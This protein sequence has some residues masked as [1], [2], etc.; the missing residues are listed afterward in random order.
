M[1]KGILCILLSIVMLVPMLTSCTQ[2]A[3]LTGVEASVYTLYT[4][5]DEKTTPEAIR[6]VELA[7]NRILFYRLNVILKLEMVSEAEYDKLIEDKFAEM[8][9]YEETRNEQSLSTESESSESG[10]SKEVLTGDKILDLLEDGKEIPLKE[11]RLDI[12]LVRGYDKYYDLASNNMLSALD[13]KLSNEAKALK[14]SIHSTF[15]N[16]A[17]VN[18]KTYG[19]PVNKAIGEYTYM[20]FDSE[21]LEK[22]NVDPNTI[23][24][25]EDLEDYLAL[26]KEGEEG[27]VPLK[28][29]KE[30]ANLQFL[31]ENGFPA[32]VDKEGYVNSAY[33][34]STAGKALKKY[35][36]MIARYQASGYFGNTA[37]EDGAEDTNR[38]AV[39]IESGSIDEINKRLDADKDEYQFSLYSNPIA[40]NENTID[41]I[42][43]VSKYVVSNELTD[44]MKIVSALNTD[45]ELMNILTY[46]VENEHYKLDDNGQVERLNENYMIAPEHAGNS[47]ITYT[48]HGESPN[49]WDDAIRQ[50]QDAIASPSLGFTMVPDTYTYEED[51]EEI[52]VNEPDYVGV[53]N[54]IIVEKYYPLFMSGTAVE[55]DYDTLYET[56]KEEITNEFITELNTLYE[57][58]ILKP[59]F[60]A[61]L[62]DEITESEGPEL[63]ANATAYVMSVYRNDVIKTLTNKLKKE[64]AEAN[65][66]ASEDDILDYVDDTLTDEYIDEHF[67]DYYSDEVVEEMINSVYLDDLNVVIDAA[68]EEMT[69]SNEYI[70]RFN[71]LKNSDAYVNELNAMLQFD[72][73]DKI[74]KK[75]DSYITLELENV[76]TLMF[77]EVELELQAE[78]YGFIEEYAEKLG[79]TEEEILISIGY[80]VEKTATEEEEGATEGET[81]EEGD[82]EP[83]VTYEPAY[84]TWFE[85]VLQDK[86]TRT[87]YQLFGDPAQKE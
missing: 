32:I 42:F 54:K 86:V 66:D 81:S 40:I 25:L 75:I 49:K 24:S 10:K 58:N 15:F 47:F 12:F 17:L 29:A 21:L 53:L 19:V 80:L 61:E 16:A 83:E 56:A 36:S 22:Y 37:V 14:S 18:G 82:E 74:V 57:T 65:P 46:G 52:T 30:S 62:R 4:I 79:M 3:D 23:K 48:L 8:E 51:G 72:A 78:V 5:V 20:V 7:L 9:A 77:E 73:P 68:I 27:I 1:K 87:Y 71:E 39:R 34:D 35:F 69:T 59:Q 63:L 44:V 70:S 50:N 13:E 38:Y 60:S 31:I 26:I 55:I 2:E 85:F 33:S 64:F 28:S 11:P 41:N 76:I 45:A 43:C 6:Q 84:T 67:S